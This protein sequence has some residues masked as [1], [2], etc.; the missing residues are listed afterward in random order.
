MD[1]PH[2]TDGIYAAPYFW[3]GEPVVDHVVGGNQDNAVQ[4][5]TL[6]PA[7]AGALSAMSNR[8]PVVKPAG[9]QTDARG[10]GGSYGPCVLVEERV[11]SVAKVA[12][13]SVPPALMMAPPAA[14][15][16]DAVARSRGCVDAAP[17]TSA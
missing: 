1:S 11:A 16:V 14:C 7:T 5:Q 8:R 17:S 10:N 12:S 15:T 2:I 13:A 4:L 9:V 3:Q 6:Q